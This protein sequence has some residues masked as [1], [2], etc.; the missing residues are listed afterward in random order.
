VE[1]VRA[2]V[3]FQTRVNEQSIAEEEDR[4]IAFRV[5]VNIGDIIVEA[6]DI[7]GDGVNIAARLESIA[8][9]GGICISST[10]Y[11]YI[12]GKV[13]IAFVDLGEQSLKNIAR[14]VRVYAA[15]AVGAGHL[16]PAEAVGSLEPSSKPL[17]LPDRPSIAIAVREHERR[18][19]ARILRRWNG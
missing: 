12:R 7:F 11:D 16:A 4:R 8:E 6:H 14:P 2:A 5:G 1:A 17:P 19:R 9:P 10:A 13:G 18:S 15:T 3:Q